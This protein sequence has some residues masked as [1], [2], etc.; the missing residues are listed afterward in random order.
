MATPVQLSTWH[1]VQSGNR[2]HGRVVR[3]RTAACAP[4]GFLL[5]AQLLIIGYLA[6]G[7]GFAH[8]GF[9]PLYPAEL[10]LAACLLFR[11][12]TWLQ[13]YVRQMARGWPLAV[14][15]TAFFGWGAFESSRGILAGYSVLESL[16]GFATHYYMLFFFV[17]WW[18]A[19][20]TS[21]R[22]FLK[23]LTRAS[24]MTAAAGIL[25]VVLSHFAPD[26]SVLALLFTPPAMPAYTATGLL[27]FAPFLSMMFYPVFGGNIAVL[28]LHPGRAAWLSMLF[29]GLLVVR[30]AGRTVL[31]RLLIV[32]V[33]LL[34]LVITA[35]PL[36]PVMEG[37]GGNLS[38]RWLLARMVTLVNSDAAESI[39]AAGGTASDVTE[40]RAIAGTKEWRK[41]FWNATLES[42]DNDDLWLLGH[43]YGFSL[44]TLIH[45]DVRTPHNFAVYLLGYTGA[46]GL[47]LYA[48]FVLALFGAIRG[49]PRG[50]FRRFLFGQTAVTLVVASFGN[51]LETPFVAVP[52]Y[53]V[54]GIAYGFARTRTRAAC[55]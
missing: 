1:A 28:L 43:G 34:I 7:R 29:G 50:P 15:I 35:G 31:R 27:A 20:G 38:P 45:E 2:L 23:L 44:G 51:G 42:L 25:T 13:L 22:W 12:G 49:L 4:R 32:S 9:A 53:L 30:G 39:I 10:F 6:F 55:A 52:F 11:G 3:S 16:R 40:I 33:C 5:S 26:N 8:I 48:G 19:L 21:A 17:G 41:R 24:I 18:L 54:T 46:I 37:R 47:A 36:M 14:M